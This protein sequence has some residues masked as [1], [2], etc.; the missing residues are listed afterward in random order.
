MFIEHDSQIRIRALLL[1]LQNARGY[2]VDTLALGAVELR[3]AFLLLA[4]DRRR[5][6]LYR[7]PASMFHDCFPD[8]ASALFAS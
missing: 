4:Q 8:R 5:S 3:E 6:C 1:R 2:V 7:T